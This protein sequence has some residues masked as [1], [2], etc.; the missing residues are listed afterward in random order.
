MSKKAKII[1]TVLSSLIIALLVL[2]GV[3]ISFDRKSYVNNN[4]K[5]VVR[6]ELGV[7]KN[8]SDTY[9]AMVDHNKDVKNNVEFDAVTNEE[10]AV[11]NDSERQNEK[12]VENVDYEKQAQEESYKFNYKNKIYLN[13]PDEFSTKGIKEKLNKI[14]KSD[15]G[16]VLPKDSEDIRK[17]TY[18]GSDYD[19]KADYLDNEKYVDKLKSKFLFKKVLGSRNEKENFYRN[20]RFY[21]IDY[22]WDK[23]DDFVISDS[24]PRF[25]KHDLLK[26]KSNIPGGYFW[27]SYDS[28][29]YNYIRRIIYIPFEQKNKMF[30]IVIEQV[31][32][33]KNRNFNKDRFNADVLQ[34]ANTILDSFKVK[35]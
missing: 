34:I 5:R 12:Q 20:L 8:Q 25:G 6:D 23:N 16:Y 10:I 24:S 21:V 2:V 18:T 30:A 3:L 31:A 14:S 9:N 27:T 7:N 15:V 11:A 33:G 17:L 19:E 29:T 32:D 13:Y 22:K 1:I 26:N 4:D 35:N 28:S